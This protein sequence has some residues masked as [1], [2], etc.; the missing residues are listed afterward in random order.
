MG[1]SILHNINQSCNNCQCQVIT[2]DNHW[3]NFLIN[4]CIHTKVNHKNQYI[5]RV[6]LKKCIQALNNHPYPSQ[7]ARQE[8]KGVHDQIDD[9]DKNR[10]KNSCE[11][12]QLWV[13]RMWEAVEMAG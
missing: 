3:G 2:K 6:Q 4:P 12:P 9:I 13:V 11:R 7:G 10:H 1:W 8:G 5:T